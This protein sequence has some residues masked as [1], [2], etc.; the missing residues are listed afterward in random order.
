M[1]ELVQGEGGVTAM[2]K[3]Y[4]QYLETLCKENDIML[5]VDE[6]QTGIGRTGTFLC[7]EQY[8]IR[9]NI[10]TLA[11]GL[12]AGLP[13][14]AILMDET[15]GE[16]FSRDNTAPPSVETLSFALV[17]LRCCAN[18]YPSK[19][20]YEGVSAMEYR[21]AQNVAEIGVKVIF[22]TINGV[23]NTGRSSKWNV[24]RTARLANLCKHYE[25]LDVHEDSILEGY[26]ILHDKAG[27]KRR[28][29]VPSSENLIKMLLKHQNIPFINQVVDIYNVIS[30]ESRLCVAAHNLDKVEGNLTVRFSD[31]T[32]T[33]LP[34][35]AEQPVP[36]KAHEYC[37]CDD[38]NEVQGS[39]WGNAGKSGIDGF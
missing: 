3:E 26:N 32:E 20:I 16:I 35:G 1:V 14:G 21:I 33:Y 4:A 39:V 6:V 19:H 38:S 18:A 22:A 27:V 11:K 29:N 28:K 2:D 10:I 36:M 15:A 30:M 8:H 31:G 13:I 5:I 34:L 17:E 25:N 9:P 24:E 37:Y 23:D 12:G 7:C